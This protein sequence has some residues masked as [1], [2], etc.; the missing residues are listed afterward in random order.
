M[1]GRSTPI[2]GMAKGWRLPLEVETSGL[3]RL[4]KAVLSAF[5]VVFVQA[6]KLFENQPARRDPGAVRFEFQI[7]A[8]A[9]VVH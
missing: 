9:N 5:P 6:V 8:H 2:S 7:P 4:A 1:R 3:R